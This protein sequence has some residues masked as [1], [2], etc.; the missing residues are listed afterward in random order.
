MPITVSSQLVKFAIRATRYFLLIISISLFL[1]ISFLTVLPDACNTY[2]RICLIAPY[3]PKISYISSAVILYG[4]FRTYRIRLTSGG[5]L[6]CR[7]IEET[8]QWNPGSLKVCDI[9]YVTC[10][11]PKKNFKPQIVAP[12]YPEV[13]VWTIWNLHDVRNVS[14]KF[15]DYDAVNV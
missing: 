15:H 5:S 8:C 13:I 2:T 7:R 3:F 14:H 12:S 10:M 11:K 6:T 4:K 1:W 9:K